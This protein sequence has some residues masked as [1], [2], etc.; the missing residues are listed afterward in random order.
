[1]YIYKSIDTPTLDRY[2]INL[3]Q[4]HSHHRLVSHTL[5]LPPRASMLTAQLLRSDTRL[6]DDEP[7]R[8]PLDGSDGL[9]RIHQQD[10]G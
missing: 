8:V 1:M 3:T 5:P 10:S 7:S 4:C 6:D 9:C 2:V